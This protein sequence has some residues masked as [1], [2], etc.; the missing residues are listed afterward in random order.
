MNETISPQSMHPKVLVPGYSRNS[1]KREKRTFCYHLARNLAHHDADNRKG[2]PFLTLPAELRQN[3]FCLVVDDHELVIKRPNR[4]T[5]KMALVCKT[6]FGDMLEVGR[7]L[8]RREQQWRDKL[9]IQRGT[10]NSLISALMD[11]LNAAGSAL[12]QQNKLQKVSRK[13]KWRAKFKKPEADKDAE[14]TL[15]EWKKAFILPKAP[16]QLEGPLQGMSRPEAMTFMHKKLKE[17]RNIHDEDAIQYRKALRADF[18]ASKVKACK[19][20]GEVRKRSRPYERVSK[21]IR[22]ARKRERAAERAKRQVVENER[23]WE[24]IDAIGA[25]KTDAINSALRMEHLSKNHIFFK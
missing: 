3:I 6:F 18:K 17:A 24:Q 21:E 16:W 12:Q 11:P 5:V 9:G 1:T 19:E 20:K 8:D 2:T 14:K 7:M 13:A 4:I 22:E 15:V 25:R 23:E 10:F